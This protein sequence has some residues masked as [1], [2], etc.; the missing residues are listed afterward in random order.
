MR[1][2]NCVRNKEDGSLDFDFNVTEAEA[3]FLM[4]HAI[5]NLV[6]NGLIKI[7]ESDAQ[8]ELDLFKQEGGVPS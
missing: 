4:D 7:S 8:Q 6:F 1:I 5:K 2:E 3:A